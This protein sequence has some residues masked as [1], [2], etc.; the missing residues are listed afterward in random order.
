MFATLELFD[1]GAY[2]ILGCS[3]MTRI[4]WNVDDIFSKVTQRPENSSTHKRQKYK[5]CC[6]LLFVTHH[7]EFELIS[8]TPWH[9][10]NEDQG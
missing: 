3:D 8:W 1:A 7:A 9:Q 5:T 10:N 2:Q 4:L 6:F